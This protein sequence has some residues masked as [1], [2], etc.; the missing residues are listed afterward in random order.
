MGFGV[1]GMWVLV[2]SFLALRMGTWPKL[3]TFVGIAT[4]I[5]YW[6]IVVGSVLNLE[7]LFT[8][9]A[10]MGGIVLAPIWYIWAGLK[11]RQANM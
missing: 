11:L 4:A 8:I 7:A 5:A 2:V 9:S 3:L 10:A 1:V 6:L